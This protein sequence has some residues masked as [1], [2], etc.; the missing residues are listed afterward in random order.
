[1]QGPP[2]VLSDIPDALA[3]SL[4]GDGA[5]ALL[6]R[7][8]GPPGLAAFDADGTLWDGDIGEDVLLDLIAGNALIDLPPDAWS[9]Y[10]ARE[11]RD[12]ADAFAYAGRLMAGL[13]EALLL[14]VSR[15]IY[16]ER[17]AGRV[18]PEIRWLLTY[19]TERSWEIYVVS[20]SNRWS[21]QVAAVALG[22]SPD[23]VCA[24]DLDVEGG[25][26][27][28]R[29]RLPVPTLDGKPQLLRAR[30]GRDPDLAFGNSVLD[31]PLMLSAKIPVAVG[32]L[33]AV[34]RP[35]NQFLAQAARRGFARLEIPASP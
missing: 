33:R 12:P 10:V 31:L 3:R 14:D 19:L 27:T 2:A 32:V 24:L 25:R 26:L 15:R 8:D 21:I 18:F 20:A 28:D 30:A 35:Q 11:R 34:G 17:F 29:V 13:S 1:M 7:L 5:E 4:C 9:E 22:L 16:A 23:R 6:Q